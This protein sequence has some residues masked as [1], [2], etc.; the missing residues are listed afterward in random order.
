MADLSNIGL[1]PNVE[2]NSGEFTILPDGQYKVVVVN[3]RI[4]PTKDGGGKLLEVKI[5]VV[6]GPNS[7]TSL[8]DRINIV[9]K[10]EIAQRIGQGQL[11]R[12]CN[13]TGTPYPPH[14]TTMM[15][16]KPIMATIK[17]E[18]FT[19]NKTGNQLKSNKVS[20]YNPVTQ[21]H[22]PQSAQPQTSSSGW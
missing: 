19:S 21:Q 2:E 5:Q 16:G 1:D 7:G 8:V 20:S 9:N 12:L 3:D 4:V 14:D 18:T 11:K 10:S 15:Y 22:K 6:E 17:T 13:L